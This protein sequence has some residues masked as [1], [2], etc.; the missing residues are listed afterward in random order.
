MAQKYL[1]SR[2]DNSERLFSIGTREFIRI[3]KKASERAGVKISPQILRK[4]HSSE[5]GELGIPDRYV[6]IFQGR[7]PKTVIAKYYTGKEL[8]RPKRICDKANFKILA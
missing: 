8:E 5:L 4:W 3:W 7:A 6:D 2:K 1:D